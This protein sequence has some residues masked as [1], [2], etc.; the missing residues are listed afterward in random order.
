VRDQWEIVDEMLRLRADLVP[1]LVE[2]VRRFDDGCEGLVERLIELRSNVVE[3]DEDVFGRGIGEFL[4]RGRRNEE[5]MVDVNFLELK[6]EI[7]D[8]DRNI[9]A[10]MEL[11]NEMVGIYN[12]KRKV[13]FLVG[14]AV[15]FKLREGKN[16]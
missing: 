3:R 10:G 2:T 6:T 16:F 7:N 13:V 4:A 8:L 14:I 11:Y 12:K 1:N 9:G 5:L 15:I